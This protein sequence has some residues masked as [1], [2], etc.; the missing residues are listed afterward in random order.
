M[1]VID[2]SAQLGLVAAWLL[3]LN[4]LLGLLL[5]VRYNPLRRWPYKRINYFTFHNWTGYIALALVA[6][7]ALL[8][9]LSTTAGW[10]W[11]DVLWPSEVPLQPTLN[12]LGALS[13]Y[14]VLLVVV[15]SYVRRRMGRKAWKAVHWASYVS[16]V[17]FFVHGVF[18]DQHLQGDPVNLFDSEKLSL[19]FCFAVVGWASWMRLRHALR[20]RHR[21]RAEKVEAHWD[22]PVPVEWAEG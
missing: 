6:A 20:R 3:T 2:I 21:G 4:V 11:K 14:L 9:P 1:N 12:I 13:L 19:V 18:V 15:T 10:V 22:A 7:H 8:L 16:A 5:S 17:L